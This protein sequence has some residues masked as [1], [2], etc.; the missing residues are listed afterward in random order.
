MISAKLRNII[1]IKDTDVM[2]NAFAK[3]LFH[4]YR[5]INKQGVFLL[6]LIAGIRH[7]MPQALASA[8]IRH[9]TRQNEVKYFVFRNTTE[10]Y[11]EANAVGGSK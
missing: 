10:F 2:T 7:W 9:W 1:R 5:A 11:R 6:H 3:E 4:F 8:S